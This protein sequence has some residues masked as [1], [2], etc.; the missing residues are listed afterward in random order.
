MH[1]ATGTMK[2][3]VLTRSLLGEALLSAALLAGLAGCADK[4]IDPGGVYVLDKDTSVYTL[5]LRAGGECSLTVASPGRPLE[6]IQANWQA[7][8]DT[9][10][11]VTFSGISWRGSWPEEAPAYWLVN[12]EG[13]VQKMCIDSEDIDCFYK[14]Q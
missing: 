1:G 6:V 14:K 11:L 2:R 12:I 10:R 5:T 3:H 13:R 9:G 8:D 7:D 4:N